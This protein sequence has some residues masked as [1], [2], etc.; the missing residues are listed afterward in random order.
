MATG[1]D[2]SEVLSVAAFEQERAAH[3]AVNTY[4]RSRRLAGRSPIF[5]QRCN[6]LLTRA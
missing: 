4:S 1:S 6:N 2:I 5:A 3:D